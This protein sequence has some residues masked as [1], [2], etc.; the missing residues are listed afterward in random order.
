MWQ[1]KPSRLSDICRYLWHFV[2][3]NYSPHAGGASGSCQAAAAF[4][5]PVEFFHVGEPCAAGLVAHAEQHLDLVA[6][7][8]ARIFEQHLE[9][10]HEISSLASLGALVRCL[11]VLI[12]AMIIFRDVVFT[13]GVFSSAK[14]R[15]TG[16]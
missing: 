1:P 10:T 8:P 5:D 7:Q 11:A 4:D 12:A 13:H 3:L 9:N 2:E 15:R 6:G 14:C 16:D